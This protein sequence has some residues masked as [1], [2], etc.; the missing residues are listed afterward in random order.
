LATTWSYLANIDDRRLAGINNV[1]LVSGH[2]STFAY[3]TTPENFIDTIT[4]RS[5]TACSPSRSRATSRH[6]AAC[7]QIDLTYS[8]PNANALQIG[9]AGRRPECASRCSKTCA[10][11]PDNAVSA[12]IARICATGQ[13]F[14]RVAP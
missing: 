1:G 13:A 14:D 10:T 5:R 6:N 7:R 4:D 12:G 2:F 11:A 9:V 8:M 3:T